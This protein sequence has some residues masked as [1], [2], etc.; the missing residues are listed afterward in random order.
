MVSE[1]PPIAV[2]SLADHIHEQLRKVDV[3]VINV[4]SKY[5]QFS[6]NGSYVNVVKR[7]MMTN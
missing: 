4:E 6:R 5:Y 1:E 3:A 2:K 7:K